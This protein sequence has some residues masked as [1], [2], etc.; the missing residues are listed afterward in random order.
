MC[1]HDC[2]LHIFSVCSALGSS[3]VCGACQVERHAVEEHLEGDSSAERQRVRSSLET[4]L[5]VMLDLIEA[6]DAG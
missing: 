4:R 5:A 3:V 2:E 1:Q 6:A